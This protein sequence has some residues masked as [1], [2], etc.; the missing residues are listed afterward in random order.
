LGR[1][2][3]LRRRCRIRPHELAQLAEE[4]GFVLRKS[5]KLRDGGDRDPGIARPAGSGFVLPEAT[6]PGGGRD[7]SPRI[8]PPPHG[9]RGIERIEGLDGGLSPRERAA[10]VAVEPHQARRNIV[11]AETFRHDLPAHAADAQDVD[12]RFGDAKRGGAARFAG[13]GSGN[14]LRQRGDI[15]RK[16]GIGE[17]GHAQAVTQRIA[18]HCGLAG[19]RARAGAARR[20]GAVGS[21]NRLGRHAGSPRLAGRRAMDEHRVMPMRHSISVCRSV[22]VRRAVGRPR[23][24]PQPFVLAGPIYADSYLSQQE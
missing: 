11:I 15:S 10:F 1:C 20:I 24:L 22:G 12:L 18:C 13:V 14:P 3:S 2:C 5:T 23:R 16:G 21:A 9:R 6:Q 8:A 17:N 4:I 7:S 19:R